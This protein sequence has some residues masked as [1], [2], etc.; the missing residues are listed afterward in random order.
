MTIKPL[1]LPRLSWLILL[2]SLYIRECSASTTP[3]RY[4]MTTTLNLPLVLLYFFS[5]FLSSS[6]LIPS[7]SS[8]TLIPCLDLIWAIPVGIHSSRS[9]AKMSLGVY[10]YVIGLSL[11][12]K[13]YLLLVA[14]SIYCHHPL[15]NHIHSVCVEVLFLFFLAC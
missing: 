14:I 6:W 13:T 3:E 4:D 10:V 9:S 8:F 5:S 2:Y 15:H 12:S 7:I 11:Y 1:C